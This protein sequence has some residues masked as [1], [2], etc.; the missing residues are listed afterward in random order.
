MIHLVPLSV[1]FTNQLIGLSKHL[2][3]ISP[4]LIACATR[5][6][7]YSATAVQCLHTLINYE[8]LPPA[9]MVEVLDALKEATHLGVEIQLKILQSLPSLIQNYGEFMF[10]NLIVELLQICYILQ[11]GNKIPV[12]VNTAL[13]TLQQVIISVFDKVVSED[14]STKPKPKTFE[15]PVDNND[16]IL[17]SPAAY[18]ALR[19]FCDICNLIERQK[20]LFLQFSHLPETVG[21]ELIES[22]LTTHSD[23]FINHVEFCYV[24]RTRAVPVLLRTFSEKRDFPV[25]VRVTRILYLL[26]RRQLSTL[27]VE[28]EV[29]I[30]L[31]THMLEPEAAPYWKRVLCMEVFQGVCSEFSLI[32][33]IY[34]AY[35]FQDGRRAVVKTWVTAI[36]K[37]SSENPSVI[38]LG[39]IST[40]IVV[41]EE[42]QSSR[43]TSSGLATLTDF[44]SSSGSRN[45]IDLI[46]IKGISLKTSTVRSS[47]IDLLDKSDPP[48]LP[49]SYLYYLALQCIS[50]L[51]E[52]LARTVF[53]SSTDKKKPKQA[54]TSLE[55]NTSN[56]GRSRSVSPSRTSD[57]I[58]LKEE[59]ESAITASLVGVCWPELLS[60]YTTFFQATMDS[61]MYHN[62]VRS[63]QKFTHASG[64]LMLVS[65][66]DAFLSLLGK[67]SVALDEVV[68][69]APNPSS[70]PGLL[71]METLVGT[72]SPTVGRDHSR[73]PSTSGPSSSAGAKPTLTSRNVLCFRALLNLGIS[74]G[75][76]LGQGWS[77][78]LET[79]QYAH[80]IVEGMKNEKRKGSVSKGVPEYNIE[81][82]PLPFSHLG[83]EFHAVENS[84]R[85]LVD[86]SKEY[87]SSSFNQLI[88]S[89]TN[90]SSLVL[91][92]PK[93]TLNG[94]IAISGIGVLEVC[95]PIF[96]LE[97]L[98]SFCKRNTERFI[99]SDPEEIKTW[100]SLTGFLM[101]IE[102][103]RSLSPDYRIRASQILNEIIRTTSYVAY[104]SQKENNKAQE[105]QYLILET[106]TN[107]VQEIVNLGLPD[108]GSNTLLTTECKM[109]V[110]VIDYLNKI[111]DQC[112]GVLQQG[113]DIVFD[114]I[115]TV[116][117]WLPD[118]N[119]INF[120]VQSRRLLVDR[121]V[122][123][124]KSG[125][126]SL[127]LVCNDFLDNLPSTCLIRL[128]DTLYKFCH[129]DSDLNIS[130]TSISFF[131]IVS[132]HLRSL[133]TTTEVK[134]DLSKEITTK[135]GLLELSQKTDNPVDSLNAM[136]MIALLRL[137]AIVNDARPQVRNGAVQV[138]FRIFEAH[139]GQLQP[140]VWKACQTIVLE[141]VMKNDPFATSTTSQ[142]QQLETEWCE[143]LGLIF[144]G[145][146][147]LYSTFID[148][149]V[150]EDHFETQWT[151]LLSHL[152]KFSLSQTRL[153]VTL[154][155]YN[156]LYTILEGI[157]KRESIEFPSS[158]IDKTWEFW[159]GQSIEPNLVTT[160]ASQDAYT[161]LVELH[162]VLSGITKDFPND[163]V[164][165]TVQL[166]KKCAAYPV[167]SP[168]SSDKDH[169]SPLQAAAFKQIESLRFNSIH[170][171]T[172][173]LTLLSELAVLPFDSNVLKNLDDLS[174]QPK[175]T[176][177]E[178]YRRPTFVSLSIHSLNLLEKGLDESKADFK[179]LIK[180]GSTR[181]IASRLLIPI[182]AKFD[183][184]IIENSKPQLWELAT[185]RFIE[186]ID[187]SMP[188]FTKI[189][190]AGNTDTKDVD[191]IN[192]LWQLF[193]DAIV[194]IL[195]AGRNLVCSGKTPVDSMIQFSTGFEKFDINSYEI[196][197]AK[198]MAYKADV[199]FNFWKNVIR[200]LFQA[201]FLYDM[202]RFSTNSSTP[203]I[204]TL[205][206]ADC[207]AKLE[208]TLSPAES[209]D[210]ILQ[211][212]FFGST[213][214]IVRKPREKLAYI[215]IEALSTI[216]RHASASEDVQILANDYLMLRIALVIYV[217]I[218][219]HPLRG[220]LM[221]MPKVQ[222]AELLFVLRQLLDQQNVTGK[223]N[224]LY[225]LIVKAVPIAENDFVILEL[226]TNLLM[227]M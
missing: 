23:I 60:S 223:P 208:N 58:N 81:T 209:I 37:L 111:L 72:L 200:A 12:V 177:A 178:L 149:F 165:K 226:C 227:K 51:S 138:L 79:I 179:V 63:A 137:A 130:F 68:D 166:L 85:R 34:H 67:F 201:S 59:S 170:S 95:D 99:H 84:I 174:K 61:E 128:V 156:C 109:H 152:Q 42:S 119:K 36:D 144:S 87:S 163:R 213:T 164:T 203:V 215:C 221:P 40:P 88:S 17:V 83:P 57:S 224:V 155:V 125:F 112:G 11:G 49:P 154:S 180:N 24:L 94:E 182:N 181:T 197:I 123:L 64:V 106:L 6:A 114:I 38:G 77:I 176:R 105:A 160:K 53:T 18:D 148:R 147:T 50:S 131:W 115:D 73:M 80:Y 142:D 91:E 65:P 35:D 1:S 8:G 30:S 169:L 194:G 143:T 90:L 39:R 44:G 183:T 3:F 141:T 20:P 120:E 117:S 41:P 45:S 198:L 86:S 29:I 126:D 184:Y 173:I 139:G 15:V 157:G 62:L 66:R 151:S 4:F 168:Y 205:I 48:T 75:P 26:I 7:K 25:T 129:Q 192:Q 187:I 92:L 103:T 82:T 185:T 134:S 132:D 55:N 193:G 43:T 220:H 146:G 22:I 16:K 101:T 31:L 153:S 76:S 162:E 195:L 5:N 210:Y 219:D 47:C 158:C 78:I 133:L 113:W 145:L 98:G 10:N 189:S 217:F 97:F 188:L 225:K 74:L 171:K 122:L 69:P 102:T 121:S 71:S 202:D 56:D 204:P 93:E 214:E 118:N 135:Q 19:V 222:R 96:L 9:R 89:I 150:K 212:A 127:Q 52:G 196:I 21:L 108:D 199:P 110:I 27:L 191:E 206:S 116:F 13:A 218:A 33:D 104:E 190:S 2:D 107:E 28:C 167:L 161:V 32:Q 54:N 124:V 186:L 172:E 136:W 175:Q 100:K 14:N 216:S 207:E 159:F 140:R 46:Q 211:N 70:K